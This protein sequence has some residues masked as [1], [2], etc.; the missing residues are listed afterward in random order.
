MYSNKD[1][2]YYR[3]FEKYN[4]SEFLVFSNKGPEDAVKQWENT[5]THQTLLTG[6]QYTIGCTSAFNGI[7]VAIAGY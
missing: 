5:L 3:Y 1:N 7:G 2:A 4:I 6:G